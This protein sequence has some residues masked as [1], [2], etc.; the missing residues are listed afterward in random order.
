LKR[1]R[2]EFGI[3]V[4]EGYK[5]SKIARYYFLYMSLIIL[6]FGIVG[7]LLGFGLSYLLID[8][9][10]N[11]YSIPII[12]QPYDF[13]YIAIAILITEFII[14]LILIF[15]FIVKPISQ[16]TPLSLILNVDTTSLKSPPR[17]L[18][19]ITKHLR[20]KNKIRFNMLFRD[21]KKTLILIFS[22]FAASFLLLIGVTLYSSITK[23][24]DSTYGTIYTYE[25]KA[26]Y[27]EPIINENH[28]AEVMLETQVTISDVVFANS[29][30]LKY[31]NDKDAG[32][33]IIFS[34][35]DPNNEYIHLTNLDSK[36]VTASTYDNGVVISKL[37]ADIYEL[38]V[39][40]RIT[41]YDPDSL[42]YNKP[43]SVTIAE[44]VPIYTT[45]SIFYD[46]NKTTT[47]LDLEAGY[48]NAIVGINGNSNN[49]LY[50]YYFLTI[51]QVTSINDTLSA[52][53]FFLGFITIISSII[54]LNVLLMISRIISEDNRKLFSIMKV[55][56]YSSR[57]I[58]R[59]LYFTY[60]PLIGFTY[61]LM[62]PFIFYLF[63]EM[64][65]IVTADMNM[66]F[67]VTMDPLLVGLGFIIIMLVTSA[68]FYINSK[69]INNI[70]LSESLKN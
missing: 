8:L 17:N 22:I 4:S 47:L 44:V 20:F 58:N 62:I 28:S 27:K 39:D 52:M 57:E 30:N 41:F 54:A 6:L 51:D 65:N 29:P 23:M 13:W 69:H 21:F 5:T 32:S 9:I 67:P 59:L 46:I 43:F 63:T 12:M 60:L 53:Y 14:Y 36:P 33:K 10:S 16:Q 61:F 38:A 24:M 3:L 37:L 56:G 48:Y 35:I 50:G 19:S 31:N 45:L 64:I 68:A 49:D 26:G 34:G 70:K 42:I 40:D 66:S 55:M 2:R 1:Q 11:L 25:Y 15:F 7:C 18:S